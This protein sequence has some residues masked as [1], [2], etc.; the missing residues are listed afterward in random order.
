MI[1][2]IYFIANHTQHNLMK[3]IKLFENF[4]KDDKHLST[5][6]P[7]DLA[8]DD[9][10]VYEAVESLCESLFKFE[11][12]E[13]W[14]TTQRIDPIITEIIDQNKGGGPHDFPKEKQFYIFVN[15]F[16]GK[17]YK[18]IEGSIEVY[19]N[20]QIEVVKAEP[21]SH[22]YPASYGK[23]IYSYDRKTGKLEF[24]KEFFNL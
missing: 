13:K 21:S 4:V 1:L 11:F 8:G 14:S 16:N 19:G 2:L 9:K 5:F 23:S 12:F 7:A 6:D 17:G 22:G 10:K 18:E 24:D 15:N 20:S 3:H